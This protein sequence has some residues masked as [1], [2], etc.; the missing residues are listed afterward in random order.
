MWSPVLHSCSRTELMA[1]MPAAGH[2]QASVGEEH[3]S[4]ASPECGTHLAFTASPRSVMQPR[5]HQSCRCSQPPCLP[6]QPAAAQ[7][8]A[9]W[10]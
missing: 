9:Q 6:G 4:D 7:D 5:A 1:A 8:S 10:G 2:S 3:R